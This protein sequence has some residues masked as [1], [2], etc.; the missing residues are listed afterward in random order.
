MSFYSRVLPMG[1]GSDHSQLN[2]MFLKEGVKGL[3][4]ELTTG[5][6]QESSWWSCLF[7]PTMHQ[8]VNGILRAMADAHMCHMEG[9][10]LID[11]MVKEELFS[12]FVGPLDA[13][14][15]DEVSKI[16]LL[17]NCAGFGNIGSF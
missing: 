17:M 16:D 2:V 4:A 12:C 8:S 15:A 14:H 10:A 1:F 3:R 11:K 7:D 5:I 6:H 9:R 13:T